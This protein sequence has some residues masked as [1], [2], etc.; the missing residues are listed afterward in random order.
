MSCLVSLTTARHGAPQSQSRA[1]RVKHLGEWFGKFRNN[2]VPVTN[3][4]YTLRRTFGRASINS[5]PVGSKMNPDV[6]LAPIPYTKHAAKKE[7]EFMGVLEYLH[8]RKHDPRPIA[9]SGNFPSVN[10]PTGP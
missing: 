2:P 4:D 5:A 10:V 8:K 1:R 9:K 6:R 3:K 7:E